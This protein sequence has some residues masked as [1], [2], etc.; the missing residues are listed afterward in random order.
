VEEQAAS[1]AAEVASLRKTAD[2]VASG[3]TPE[4]P[5]A[6]P[7][8]KEITLRDELPAAQRQELYKTFLL[9]CMTGD[10]VYAP[11]GS[12]ITI[13]RDAS[14]F[15]RLSQLGDVLGLSP[16]EVSDV[17]RGLAEQA[18]RANAQSVLADGMLTRDKTEKLK[19]LQT[20]LG[21]PEETAQKVIRSITSGKQ[22]SSLQ[23]LV[24]TGKLSLAD[25][26]A[27]AADGVDVARALSLDA[28]SSLLRNEVETALA[29]GTGEWDE[30]RW[31]GSAVAALQLDAAKAVPELRKIAAEKRRS[32]LVQAVALLRQKDADAVAKA[33]N[34]LR[35][36]SAAA[37]GAP[38]LAWPVKEEL[39]DLYSVACLAGQGEAELAG[40][41]EV[42]QL[43]AETCDALRGVVRAGNFRLER[44]DAGSALY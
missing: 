33:L 41:A 15:T 30:A 6:P 39:M 22:A 4:A 2:A 44:A 12:T 42:L 25:V 11:M 14:E 28:R 20:Q 27:M 24:A 29:S 32:Q 9:F 31:A 36:A 10:Q 26:E 19:E 16:L 1:D 8:Q 37:P 3:A 17:H 34:N 40:L 23:A 5:A 35:A 7:C 38:P 18:F 21:L 43:E 13:E